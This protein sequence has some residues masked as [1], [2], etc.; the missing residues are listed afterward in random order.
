MGRVLWLALELDGRTANVCGEEAP[1]ELIPVLQCMV[2]NTSVAVQIQV[3]VVKAM[4]N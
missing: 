3:R 4:S 2:V 1:A